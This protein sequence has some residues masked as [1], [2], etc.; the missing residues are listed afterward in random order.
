MQKPKGGGCFDENLGKD[1]KRRKNPEATGIRKRR[2]AHL[3]PF[4]GLP[5]RHLPRDGHCHARPAEN[6]YLQLCKIQP[7][8]LSSARLRGGRRLRLSAFGKH[9]RMSLSAPHKRSAV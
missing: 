2:K 7:R 4:F 6:A 1:N 3:F 5:F 8:A 9:R